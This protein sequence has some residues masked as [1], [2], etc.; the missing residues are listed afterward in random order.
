LEALRLLVKQKRAGVYQGEIS[1]NCL[2]SDPL[3][4]RLFELVEFFESEG[5]EMLLLSLP[6]YLS[7]ETSA[8]MD[9]FFALRFSDKPKPAQPS[10]YAYKFRL[11]P[12]SRDDLR[13]QLARLDRAHW[14][15][16]L[17]YNPALTSGELGEFLGGGDT[18]AQGKTRCL[19]LRTRLE[20]F[21]NGKAVS[22]K[23]FPEFTVG[24]L[25]DATVAQVWHSEAYN[26][27]RETVAT[28]GL[29]PVCA[30]C[31][32]LYSRGA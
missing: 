32:L 15:L 13:D 8:K 19:A 5:V 18:P 21:P 25:R 14:R 27:V 30:Q 24:N 28:C 17:R 12:A 9:A 26:R 29:M 1:V 16:K 31:N 11:N 22:C 10:W 4:V 6:W 23:F 20:V 2:I 7:D 3:V